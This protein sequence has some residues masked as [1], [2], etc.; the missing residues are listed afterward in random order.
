MQ[1]NLFSLVFCLLFSAAHLFAQTKQL[2]STIINLQN[3]NDFKPVGNNWKVVG[4]VYYDINKAESGK[5]GSGSGIVANAPSDKAK[6]H[7]FT[8]MEHGDIDL[9][10]EFMMDKG[11]NSGVYLQGRYEIQLF[12][13]WGV[14]TPTSSDCGAIYQ[15]WDESRPEGRKGYEGHPPAQNV[16]KAPGLWQHYRIVFQAPRFNASGEKIANA[17]FIKVIHNG[18]TI[19]ENV[20]VT[21]PTRSAGF[22]DEKPTGP[23]MIQGD[24]GPVAIRN[25]KYKSYGVEPVTLSN[26][27]L[28]AYEGKIKSLAELN[29]LTPVKELKIDVL[30]H[31]GSGTRDNFGG[32]ITGTIR[33]PQTGEYLFNLSLDWIPA[34]N[35]PDNPNG[36]GSFR[37]GDKQ[38]IELN[39]ASGTGSAMVSLQAGEHP[40]TLSYFKNYGYWYARSNNI[41]LAVEGPGIAYTSL[42]APLR[43][44]EP[45]SA[46]TIE[47]SQ[48]PTMVRSFINHK[49]KKRTHVLSVGEPTNLNYTLD[50]STGELLH[51]WRGEFIEATPMWHGRGETQLALP[52]GSVLELSGK[53][54]LASL[55]NQNTAWPDSSASYTYVGY[56][57]DKA[58][59]RPVFK[60]TLGTASIKE[61]FEPQDGGRKLS[62]SF[63]VTPGQEKEIWCR[64]AE[65]STI[66]KLPNGLY[67]INDKEFL[68]EL[69]AKAKPVIRNTSQNT[70][71]LLLPVTAENKAGSVTYS[72]VW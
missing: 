58:S 8:K 33:V 4:D 18:V 36:F 24:H 22:T 3:L 38:L 69:P 28:K 42:S 15:R 61:S 44:V 27:Q 51:V 54:S 49:G 65:G 53:P 40:I 60:Y 16:S 5:T 48:E 46:I 57:I 71:E 63:Q 12:D 70:K 55:T 30:D 34:D 10:L 59:H 68:V 26:L 1:A 64:V 17:R 67:A 9:E 41:T 2:P 72:I 11:S 52:R 21:G 13:S 6:D 31:Q 29:S 66:T 50:L 62:H 45:V 47:A 20:E 37:I 14:A 19:H 35:R 32:L 56:D 25:I 7:L 43:V 23:L 39:G